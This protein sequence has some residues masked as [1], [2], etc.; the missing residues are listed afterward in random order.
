MT[1][2]GISYDEA[3]ETATFLAKDDGASDE[4]TLLKKLLAERIPIAIGYVNDVKYTAKR[5]GV[6][7]QITR[8]RLATWIC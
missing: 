3:F 1:C 7:E 5:M 4:Y 6:A 2:R 8:P